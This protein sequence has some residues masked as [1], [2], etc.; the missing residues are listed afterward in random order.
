MQAANASIHHFRHEQLNEGEEGGGR[1]AINVGY[2]PAG[3]RGE[4][5]GTGWLQKALG[6]MGRY[7]EGGGTVGDDCFG[8]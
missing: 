6:H 1:T 7:K 8:G 3:V 2:G 5:L 4:G